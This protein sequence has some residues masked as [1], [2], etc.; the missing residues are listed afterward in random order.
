MPQPQQSQLTYIPRPAL[1]NP[2]MR[3][4]SFFSKDRNESIIAKIASKLECNSILSRRSKE[5]KSLSP[6]NVENSTIEAVASESNAY[7]VRGEKKALND[8]SQQTPLARKI[9]NMQK[10]RLNEPVD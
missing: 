5:F 2:T 7:L 3:N 10:L 8:K 4:D 1:L 9:R 6:M